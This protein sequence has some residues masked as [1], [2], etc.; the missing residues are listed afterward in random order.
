MKKVFKVLS[1]I[2][3]FYA[4]ILFNYTR[5]YKIKT[6]SVFYL[7]NGTTTTTPDGNTNQ[8][9]PDS[10]LNQGQT[11]N[12]NVRDNTTNNN[13]NQDNNIINDNRDGMDNRTDPTTPGNIGDDGNLGADTDDLTET[14]LVNDRG[15]FNI[16]I[17]SIGGLV[18]GSLITY[19]FVTPK[20]IDS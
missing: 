4:T 9:T 12:N 10:N 19:F 5:G 2:L 11:P 16:V 14:N 20:R 6:D 17:A 8:N 1:I 3:F 18:V 13:T 7:V 15:I